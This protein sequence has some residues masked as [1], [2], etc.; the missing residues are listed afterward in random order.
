MRRFLATTCLVLFISLS[1]RASGFSLYE[2]SIR[3][4]GVLGAFSAF[5]NHVSTIYY[6]PAGLS[7]LDGFRF[8]GGATIIAP[9]TTFRGPLPY[10]NT[11]YYMKDQN[12]TVPNAYASYQITEGLTAGIG[13]Y[14]PFG[15]GTRWP[16]NWVGR[17]EAVETK[18]NTVFLNPAVGYTLPD[19]GIGEI[20]VGAGLQMAIAGDVKLSRAVR[21]FVPEGD[22]SLD[23]NLDKPAYGYNFG[24]LYSPVDDVTLGFTYRS[25][26]EVTFNGDARFSNLPVS[27]FPTGTKGGTTIDLPKSWVAAINVK[28]LENLALEFDYV[29]WGWS[30]YDKLVI[31]FD[32]AVPALGGTSLTSNR[33]YRDTYQLRLGAE[34]T[35]F[36]VDNLTLRA[37]IAFDNTPL[38]EKTMDPTLPDSDRLLFSGGASYDFTNYLA[39]DVSYIFIRAQQ[40]K[41]TSSQNGLHG[42]YNT[43]AN[44]P[45]FG[46]TLKF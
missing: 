44:L 23:G 37:G 7:R 35:D 18:L 43:Y 38:P 28:P 41:D 4:N 13:L 14:A 25:Q 15:L 3:A 42:V 12:F 27:G 6:N 24:V 33:D 5:A 19:F 2:A 26:V 40:R 8:S 31:E 9:R 30:S 16:D 20:H 21:A 39:L 46:L 1:A 36:G 11:K 17:S 22:F 32:Q 10:S 29:W 45:S 34:Y